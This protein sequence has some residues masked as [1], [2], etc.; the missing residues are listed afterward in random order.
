MRLRSHLSSSNY[1]FHKCDKVGIIYNTDLF[2]KYQVKDLIQL[3]KEEGKKVT[4]LG[5]HTVDSGKLQDSSIDLNQFDFWGSLRPNKNVELLLGQKQDLL[6]CL[7]DENNYA[8]NYLVT[9]AE[10]NFKVGIS[11]NEDSNKKFDL[12]VKCA[13]ANNKASELIKYLKLIA[14]NE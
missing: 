10:S 2:I 4:S 12:I 13:H 1:S 7:D 9:K 3:L 6:I 11:E 14:S 5:F 8:I